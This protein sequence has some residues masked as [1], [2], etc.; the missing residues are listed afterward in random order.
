M[1]CKKIGIEMKKLKTIEEKCNK[2]CTPI[3]DFC[4]NYKDYGE[5]TND[6]VQGIGI[7]LVDDTEVLASDFCTTNFHCFNIKD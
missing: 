1:Y 3:C 6:E 7:C 2:D 4:I 5:Q